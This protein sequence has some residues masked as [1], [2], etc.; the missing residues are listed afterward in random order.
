MSR[1]FA[2]AALLVLY[3]PACQLATAPVVPKAQ[4]IAQ[5]ALGPAAALTTYDPPQMAQVPILEGITVTVSGGYV[6]LRAR[7]REREPGTFYSGTQPGGWCLMVFMNTDQNSATGYT[8]YGYDLIVDGGNDQEGIARLLDGDW[9][10]IGQAG[11]S[12][13]GEDLEV[14]APLD[15][16]GALDWKLCTYSDGGLVEIYRGS[17][18]AG[19]GS[20]PTPTLALRNSVRPDPLSRLHTGVRYM[21]RDRTR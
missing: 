8:A 12:V 1:F 21:D 17:I 18:T 15:M 16:D 13:A 3:L 11:I 4:Q 7:L 2:V 14:K 19:S 5:E 6:R 20:T 10:E 9:N